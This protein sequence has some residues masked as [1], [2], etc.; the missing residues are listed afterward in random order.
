MSIKFY[1]PRNEPGARPS[2]RFRAIVP[3]KG[4]RPQDGVIGDVSEAT[5]NDIVV[6]AK[7]TT[8][9]EIEYLINKNIRYVFD[10]CDDKFHREGE[11]WDYACKNATRVV[12]T[13]PELAKQIKK[14]TGKDSIIIDDP[15]ERQKEE[16]K[17]NP[18]KVIK[19]ATYGAGKSFQRQEWDKVINS[20]P[21]TE[22]HITIGKYEKYSKAY[23]HY[24]QMK[25]YEWSYEK[26]GEIV[27]DSDI[28]IIPIRPYSTNVLFKSPNR[29]I[30]AIQQGR[31]VFTNPGVASY[32]PLRDF[33]VMRDDSNFG[34][35]L[36]WALNNKD[37]VI[38]KI[39]KG[40]DY[41]LKHHT[42]EI[43]GQRWVELE[44]KI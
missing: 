43:I 7:K 33:V 12:T 37:Q 27:R 15:T 6:M 40:Q 10:I 14:I 44:N 21:N 30:D 17:F 1:I 32:E 16:P 23:A 34:E 29:I 3:L 2:R 38:D 26:Q 13:T 41:I 36:K 18:G 39:K 42:P 11:T 19:F 5:T 8:K 31:L 24:K 28:T 4:M 35:S 9:S 22:F 25:F 20:L